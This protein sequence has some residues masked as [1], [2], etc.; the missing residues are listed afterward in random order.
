MDPNG[1]IERSISIGPFQPRKVVHLERWPVFS[2]LSRL[3]R[4]VPFIF[5]PKFPEI[6]VE[7]I[8]SMMSV[9]TSNPN[10]RAAKSGKLTLLSKAIKHRIVIF[11]IFRLFS[12]NFRHFSQR[13]RSPDSKLISLSFTQRSFARWRFPLI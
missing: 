13:F 11:L 5:R 7:W 1:Q 12:P 2:K 9:S 6:L 4:S 8:A 10:S 3:D